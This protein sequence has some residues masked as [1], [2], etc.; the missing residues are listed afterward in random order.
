LSA[1]QANRPAWLVATAAGAMHQQSAVP[2]ALVVAICS[3]SSLI[4]HRWL[5]GRAAPAPCA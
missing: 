1:G 4:M 3:T 5:V 2:M